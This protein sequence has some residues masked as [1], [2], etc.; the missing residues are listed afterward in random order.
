MTNCPTPEPIPD[1]LFAL[2]VAHGMGVAAQR[3]GFP[4]TANGY[5][6]LLAQLPK[7]DRLK[8][9]AWELGW[10]EAAHMAT[11][12]YDTKPTAATITPSRR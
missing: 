9:W 8:V 6:P 12:A 10:R 2:Y 1:D 4:V 7:E 5:V 3:A 11:T